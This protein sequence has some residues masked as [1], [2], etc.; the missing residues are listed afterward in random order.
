[1]PRLSELRHPGA[2]VHF[3]R[4]T[5][6]SVMNDLFLS[7]SGSGGFLHG[8]YWCALD[9]D[10]ALT[11]LVAQLASAIGTNFQR[12]PIAGF[13]E[14]FDKDL[15]TGLIAAGARP[16]RR[17]CGHSVTGMPADMRPL[18]GYQTSG[19]EQPLLRA[20]L[21]ATT[22]TMMT[23]QIMHRRWR[24]DHRAYVQTVATPN[25]A[26]RMLTPSPIIQTHFSVVWP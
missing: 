19:F 13:D 11:P 5:E 22:T 10:T 6:A 15:L 18:A 1:M 3:Y 21:H 7:Q 12:V 16:T 17:P 24:D 25:A 4:G 9:G 14:L 20:R 26:P 8:I 23:G 2:C